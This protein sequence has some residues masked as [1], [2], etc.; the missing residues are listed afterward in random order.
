GRRNPKRDAP[1]RPCRAGD[2]RI[3]TIARAPVLTSLSHVTF[4]LHRPRSMDNV[5]AVARVLKNFGV[6]RLVLVDPLSTSFDRA[7]K[8]AVGAEDVLER[9]YV[10]R[11]LE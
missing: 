4:V 8:L 1:C 9:M 3:S 6:G 5:G 11:T 10:H 7:R 2:P